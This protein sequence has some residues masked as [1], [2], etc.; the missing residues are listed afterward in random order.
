MTK[1]TGRPVG[2]PT[3]YSEAL[4]DRICEAMINGHDLMS[5]CARPGFPDRVTVYRWMWSNP[6]FATR[7]DKVREALGDHAAYQIGQIAANCTNETA[8]ADRVRLA[9]LQWR[10]SK[11]SPR[12]Y[13]DRKVNEVVGANGG[14]IAIEERPVVIDAKSLSREERRQMRAFLEA[15][16]AGEADGQEESYVDDRREARK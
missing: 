13:S 6:E 7:I 15:Q 11:L 5:I 16:V 9:A 14:A 10:A 4:A 2:R 12:R 1:L 8:A 3:K